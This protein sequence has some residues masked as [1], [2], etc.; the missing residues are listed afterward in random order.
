MSMWYEIKDIAD[1]E[2]SE[3]GNSLEIMFR[4]D[5]NGNNYVDVPIDFVLG[6]LGGAEQNPVQMQVSQ[7]GEVGEGRPQ[8]A[9]VVDAI[10]MTM[11]NGGVCV[12]TGHKGDDYNNILVL[13]LMDKSQLP[14][15]VGLPEHAGKRSTD[16]GPS[17]EIEFTNVE[18]VQVVIDALNTIKNVVG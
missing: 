1:I 7:S 6:I 4:N 2:I 16:V 3:D 17:I 9:G 14:I 13:S 15:G 5:R 11:G 12:S 10:R 8:N 18:S